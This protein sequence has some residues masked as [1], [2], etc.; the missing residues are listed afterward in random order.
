MTSNPS[1][2]A[3]LR[4]HA[5]GDLVQLYNFSGDWQRIDDAVLGSIR[6]TDVVDHLSGEAPMREDGQ[7]VLEPYGALWLTTR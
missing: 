1:V 4:R 2:L 5:A 6:H 3:V 7:V